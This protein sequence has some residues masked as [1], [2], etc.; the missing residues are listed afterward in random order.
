MVFIDFA[1]CRVT[2]RSTTTLTASGALELLRLPTSVKR[3]MRSTL[4]RRPRAGAGRSP[5][6]HKFLKVTNQKLNPKNDYE[7]THSIVGV[8]WRHGWLR[9][10]R[11]GQ[12]QQS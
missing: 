9:T 3:S 4:E 12:L 1:P 7:E 6:G 5:S 8:G 2:L 10:G 11:H